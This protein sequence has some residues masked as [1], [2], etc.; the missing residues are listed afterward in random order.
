M[1]NDLT[2][3]PGGCYDGGAS[4]ADTGSALEDDY[5][6]MADAWPVTASGHKV[7]GLYTELHVGYRNNAAVGTAEGTDAEQGIYMVADGTHSGSRCCFDFGNASRDNCYGLTGIM[8]TL[9]LGDGFW[10][11]GEGSAPWFMADFEL[12]V[13][14]GTSCSGWGFDPTAFEHLD[15]D[16]VI[17]NDCV[18]QGYNPDNRSMAGVPFAF[19]VLSTGTEDSTPQYA[20]RMGDATSGS[21]T[22]AYDGPIYITWDLGGSIILGIGGDNS[23]WSWG[24]FF[25]GVMTA[26]RPS[27]Q[28]DAAVYQNVREAGYGQ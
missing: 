2:A 26:D 25:E 23:N 24:T 10:G 6:A 17:P 8:A 14:A 7:Y 28:A 21:M 1:G 12:G 11:Y 5:E 22:T 19:G 13:W 3:A 27:E 9:F 20:L 15:N 18:D 4:S 16:L